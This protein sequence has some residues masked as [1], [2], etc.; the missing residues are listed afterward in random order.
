MKA[1]WKRGIGVLSPEGDII[2]CDLHDHWKTFLAEMNDQTLNN[3]IAKMRE[4]TNRKI[5]INADPE[6]S[7]QVWATNQSNME[8]LVFETACSRGWA[9]IGF[10]DR[11]RHTVDFSGNIAFKKHIRHYGRQI[12]EMLNVM[13]SEYYYDNPNNPTMEESIANDFKDFLK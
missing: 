13:F 11:G 9:R 3:K 2:I 12:A 10:H 6:D 1:L 7:T 4:K 5:A 8:R